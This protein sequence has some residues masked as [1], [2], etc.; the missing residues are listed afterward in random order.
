MP[1]YLSRVG[2]T[3]EGAG[4]LLAEGGTARRDAIRTAVESVG[5]TVECCYFAFG[6]DDLYVIGDVPDAVAAAAM[7]I[8][9][10]AAGGAHTETIALLT[11]AEVD[12]AVKRPTDFRPPGR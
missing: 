12:E 1:K 5:G 3:A 10:A 7:S 9:T 11:P 4:E 8:R 2:Y 6:T